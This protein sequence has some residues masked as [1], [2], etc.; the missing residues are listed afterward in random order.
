MKIDNGSTSKKGVKP[1]E[2]KASKFEKVL[3]M[4]D[5]ETIA[6]AIR[7]LLLRDKENENY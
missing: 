6:K 7:D 4:S 3:K 2:R 5:E 1:I